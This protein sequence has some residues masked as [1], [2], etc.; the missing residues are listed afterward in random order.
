MLGNPMCTSQE[1]ENLAWHI[2][3]L[4]RLISYS[5]RYQ[6]KLYI[7]IPTCRAFDHCMMM[8]TYGVYSFPQLNKLE[9][10]TYVRSHTFMGRSVEV[11]SYDVSINSTLY[12]L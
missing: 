8:P 11:Y 5:L 9:N 7:I 10:A 2:A 4:S 1:V 3:T 6:T 12:L